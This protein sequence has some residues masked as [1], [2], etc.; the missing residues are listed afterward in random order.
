MKNFFAVVFL[1]TVSIIILIIYYTSKN[2]YCR[3]KARVL[4]LRSEKKSYDNEKI[5]IRQLIRGMLLDLQS[6]ERNW[7]LIS[8]HLYPETKIELTY[9]FMDKCIQIKHRIRNVENEELI[10]LKNLGSQTYSIN[11]DLFCI[12]VSL[13]STIVT[14]I[15]YFLLEHIGKQGN[16]KNIKIVTSGG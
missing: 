12:N 16:A 3:Y 14:D 13:N 10:L 1:T 11:N 8:S 5:Y 4:K 2:L 7:I 6:G 15:V 9:N